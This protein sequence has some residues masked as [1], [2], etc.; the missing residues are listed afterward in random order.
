MNTE[1]Q[2]PEAID[3]S[4]LQ[5]IV[6]ASDGHLKNASDMTSQVVR[7]RLRETGF[8]RLIL[9]DK[10]ISDSELVMLPDTELPVVVE[11]MEP[12]SPG[13][14]TIS[15]NDTADTAF[16]RGDKFVV[17]FHKISTPDF[18][19]NVDELRTYKAEIRS[20]IC[21][22]ALKDMHTEDDTQFV[23][24]LDRL[25][26]PTNGVGASGF[27]QNFII[28]GQITRDTYPEIQNYLEDR[29]LNN[30]LYLTNRKTAKAF[31]KFDRN[32]IGGDLA[33]KLFQKGLIA[34]QESEVMGIRHAFTIKRN[35]VP[36]QAV[37]QFSEPA[38]LGKAYEL[39]PATMYVE[40]KEDILRFHAVTKLGYTIANV[41]AVNKVT[42]QP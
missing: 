13:A 38:F 12:D 1:I 35:L 11:L 15:F 23:K 7:R 16:Y 14:K 26:G 27:Q 34:L 41:S 39:M 22:N 29:E 4:L 33:E 9:P 36:D 21:D 17:I 25:I 37:Y 30:G 6:E 24:T 42:F 3:Q 19:K 32:E 40:K 2:S 20:I 8:R 28:N 31:L 18:T 10:P 5:A